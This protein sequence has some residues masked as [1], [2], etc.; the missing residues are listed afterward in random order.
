MGLDIV[1]NNLY[2]TDK[3]GEDKGYV[4]DRRGEKDT[5]QLSSR[6]NL[7][8]QNLSWHLQPLVWPQLL[9]QLVMSGHFPP[10]SAAS[11]AT[12]PSSSPTRR[13]ALSSSPLHHLPPFLPHPRPHHKM[14]FLGRRR[15]WFQGMFEN[16]K[17]SLICKRLG[18]L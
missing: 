16:C 18:I 4:V 1:Q 17:F 2:R 9:P 14:L 13:T 12:P 11:T 15:L 8:L 6:S 10:P 3:R 5:L 7:G